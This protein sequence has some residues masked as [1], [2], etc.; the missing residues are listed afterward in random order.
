MLAAEQ[1]VR[2][3]DLLLGQASHFGF[4]FWSEVIRWPF[5]H[6]IQL[7]IGTKITVID[8]ICSIVLIA[9]RCV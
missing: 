2:H 4:S 8:Y 7:K 5:G 6:G 3:I 1:H 9:F